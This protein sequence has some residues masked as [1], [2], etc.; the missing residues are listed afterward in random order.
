MPYRKTVFANE[1]FYHITNHTVG[2]EIIFLNKI[3][4][5]RALALINFYRFKSP[6]SF[7]RFLQL[8]KE[9]QQRLK[10]AILKSPPLVEIYAFSLMPNHFHFL[11]KQ[12][13]ENG[14]SAFIS[15]FQNG[16]AKYYNLKSGRKGSLFCQMFKGIL[17][18]TEE[19]FIHVSR[20]IHLN[21]VTAFLIKINQLE[22]YIYNSF[23]T[24][25][26][27]FIHPFIEKNLILSR[28]KTPEVYKKFVFDQENY[29]KEL[30][31]IKSLVLE[32]YP[33]FMP[34]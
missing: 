33:G 16:Y 2:N 19:Q 8:N 5:K 25:M 31:K 1:Q 14:I 11:L 15:N 23:S 29:Q 27:I 20:Y 24:Y 34:K 22:D 6:M 28:F 32:K 13:A 21:P 30:A 9:K 18:E 17:I 12:L 7:S 3:A 4:L 26:E 10:E